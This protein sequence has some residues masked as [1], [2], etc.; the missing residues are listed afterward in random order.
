MKLIFIFHR[1]PNRFFEALNIENLRNRIVLMDLKMRGF[2]YE[3]KQDIRIFVGF[4]D[5]KGGLDSLPLEE[6]TA[7]KRLIN[8]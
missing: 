8:K 2:C 6:K 1:S 4:A 7:A 3:M 5:K